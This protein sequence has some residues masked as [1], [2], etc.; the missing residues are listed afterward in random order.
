MGLSGRR[1]TFRPASQ[2]EEGVFSTDGGACEIRWWKDEFSFNC[3]YFLGESS[4]Q[5]RAGFLRFE[6]KGGKSQIVI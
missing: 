4:C 2:E 3:F 6:E 1:G 5:R